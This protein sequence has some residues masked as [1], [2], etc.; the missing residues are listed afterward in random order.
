MKDFLYVLNIIL[1][2]ITGLGGAFIGGYFTRK[3]QNDLLDKEIAREEIREKRNEVN[4]TMNVYNQIIKID[5]EKLLVVHV[6]GPHVEFEIKLYQEFI[7]PL[8][9]DNF[10][11]IHKDVADLIKSL[12]DTIQFCSFNEELT[13]DD[14]KGLANEY[15]KLIKIIQKHI[16]DYRNNNK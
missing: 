8:I 6:G 1:P 3:S 4:K 13:W 9:Y 10:H 5:G 15:Y 2:V 12:D 7:R 16:E 14:N 11:I